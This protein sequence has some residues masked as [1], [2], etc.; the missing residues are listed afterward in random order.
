MTDDQINDTANFGFM[1][2]GIDHRLHEAV[3]LILALII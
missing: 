2:I 1:H 3:I